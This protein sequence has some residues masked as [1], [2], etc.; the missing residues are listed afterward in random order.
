M[1][2]HNIKIDYAFKSYVIREHSDLLLKAKQSKYL[3]YAIYQLME[4]GTVV[5]DFERYEDVL[6][7]TEL[8]SECLDKGL[9]KELLEAYKINEA[10]WRRL[11][12][13]RQRVEEM[14]LSGPCLFLTLTFTDDTLQSTTEK[15]RRVSVS[16]YLKQFNCKYVANIDFG[17]ENHRE[18]YH[19]VIQCKKIDTTSW[20][21]FGAIYIE[22]VRSNG[23]EKNGKRLSKYVCKLSNHAIKE[24]TRRCSLLYS[25]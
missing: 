23:I 9:N 25:R 21:K 8:F 13:L 2:K 11:R 24:T 18:H 1:S 17:A 14:L 20:H 22:K 16:R 3:D 19:A 7:T 4:N 5:C 10:Y 6:T 15:Q 12:R